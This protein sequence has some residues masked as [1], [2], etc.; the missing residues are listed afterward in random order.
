MVGTTNR[1]DRVGYV[2]GGGGRRFERAHL[3]AHAS[4]AIWRV[5]GWLILTV[6]VWLFLFAQGTWWWLASWGLALW[7]LTGILEE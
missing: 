2:V 6:A 1:R 3:V 5:L 4:D 7:G